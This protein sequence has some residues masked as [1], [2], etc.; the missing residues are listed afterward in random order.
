MVYWGYRSVDIKPSI[1]FRILNSLNYLYFMILVYESRIGPPIFCDSIVYR[2]RCPGLTRASRVQDNLGHCPASRALT[3]ATRDPP[4]PPTAQAELDDLRAALE[5]AGGEG[6]ATA[7]EWRG[8]A[9]AT[10]REVASVRV[11]ARTL[12]E[13]KDAQISSLRVSP[14][15]CLTL[16]YLD[17][18]DVSDMYSELWS[19]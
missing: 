16:H 7:A 9:E 6:A 12:M 4:G 19:V 8:Q 1:N 14:L 13:E 17:L 5:R 2:S 10:E 15:I 11:R 3:A 18:Q